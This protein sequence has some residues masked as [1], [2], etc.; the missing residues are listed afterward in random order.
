MCISKERIYGQWAGDKKGRPEDKNRCIV[1]V[2]GFS[3]ITHQCC[4]KRGH[5]ENGLYCKQHA[6]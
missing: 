5:G 4:R 6:K 2:H 1:A 3:Y